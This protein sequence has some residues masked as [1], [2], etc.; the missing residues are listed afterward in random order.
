MRHALAITSLLI[1]LAPLA[2]A[3]VD[4]YSQFES[5]QAGPFLVGFEPRPQ[6][7][8]ANAA[9]SLVAQVADAGTGTPLRDVPIS[10]IIGGPADFNER[11]QMQPDGTG[12]FVASIVYPAAGNYSA[13]VLIRDQNNDT[14]AVDTE[15]QVFP[16]LPVRIRPVDQAVDVYTGQRTPLAFE[17]VDPLTLAR[18]DTI[19]DLRIKLERWSDDHTQFLGEE[20]T[21]PTKTGAGVWRIDYVFPSSGMYHIRFASEAGGFTYAEVPLLHVY[22]TSP[23]SAGIED[24]DTPA[25]APLALVGLA[26]LVALLRRR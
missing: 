14:H 18:K 8:F 25:A 24:K 16:D 22:A 13:R 7:P 9:S 19:P 11:K 15:F 23:A 4:T 6:P 21:T 3:H 5:L 20:E 26:L 12:Y 10:I 2:S 17:I 1:L